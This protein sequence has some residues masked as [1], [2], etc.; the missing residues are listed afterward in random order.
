MA[1]LASRRLAGFDVNRSPEPL[2]SSSKQ[3]GV[4]ALKATPNRMLRFR[5]GDG[6]GS[7]GVGRSRGEKAV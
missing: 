1:A 3:Q 6:R 7:K 2:R 4:K 5:S